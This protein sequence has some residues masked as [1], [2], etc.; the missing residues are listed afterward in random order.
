MIQ[1]RPLILVVEDD[2]QTRELYEYVL[3]M[4]GYDVAIAR[5]GLAA[6][7]ILEQHLPDVILL[8][9]DLPHVSG[10]DVHQEVLAHAETASIPIVVVTGTTW[11]PPAGVFRALQKPISSDVVMST[12][13]EA[14]TRDDAAAATKEGSDQRPR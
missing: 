13:R 7:R 11:A 14:L 2:Q 5:D 10:F 8:D 1:E 6:L 12:L 3:R 9:L 4:A